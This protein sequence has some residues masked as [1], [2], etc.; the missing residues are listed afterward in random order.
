ML[1]AVSFSVEV[2]FFVGFTRLDL[3]RWVLR[4]KNYHET[5]LN[6]ALV[7]PVFVFVSQPKQSLSGRTCQFLSLPLYLCRCLSVTLFQ[8]Y[9]IRTLTFCNQNLCNPSVASQS[10]AIE[11][12]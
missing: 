6:T 8:V 2:S 9:M 10:P 12:N 5:S 4:I 11:L 1:F 3:D 7:V